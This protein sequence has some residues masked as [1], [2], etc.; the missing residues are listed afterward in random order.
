M[1]RMY[2]TEKEK[3]VEGSSGMNG[4]KRKRDKN[5]NRGKF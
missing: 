1:M 3:K 4:G 5:G 2:V